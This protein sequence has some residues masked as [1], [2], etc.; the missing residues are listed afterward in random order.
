M[1]F[2]NKPSVSLTLDQVLEIVDQL[3]TADKLKVAKRMQEKERNEAID[4]LVAIF[5]KVKLSAK[6][7]S[8][9][10]EEERTQVHAR[11]KAHAGRR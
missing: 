1:S 3:S 9:I 4:D 10:V 2:T 11:Q 5:S 7:V 6:A 8:A